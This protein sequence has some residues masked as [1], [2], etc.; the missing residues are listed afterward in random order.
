MLIRDMAKRLP[1]VGDVRRERPTC[2]DRAFL[3]PITE[4]TVVQVNEKRLWYRVRFKD[5]FCECYKLP[6]KKRSEVV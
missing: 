6:V 1:K 5:G 2:T 4:C 3:A